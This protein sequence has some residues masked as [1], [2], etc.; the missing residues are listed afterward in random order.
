MN[1]FAFTR[2]DSNHRA[3]IAR[4]GDVHDNE[5]IDAGGGSSAVVIPHH[6]SKARLILNYTH[7]FCHNLWGKRD[8][9]EQ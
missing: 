5:A 4:E 6:Y 3:F 8:T 2:E 9:T 1:V 7:N